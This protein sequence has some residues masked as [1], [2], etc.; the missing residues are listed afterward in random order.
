MA[1]TCP[2]KCQCSPQH[3]ICRYAGLK[4]VPKT[5]PLSVTYIDLS[6]N[7]FL[8]I[9]RNA[10]KNMSLLHTLVLEDCGQKD[11]ITLPSSIEVLTIAD[12]LLADAAFEVMLSTPLPWLKSLR[13]QSNQLNV[14]NILKFIPPS[15]EILQ[16]TG[17]TM[18]ILKSNHLKCCPNLVKFEC[19]YCNLQRIEPNAFDLTR[20][21]S[22]ISLENNALI[23]LPDRIFQHTQKIR[24][25]KL[26]ANLMEKFNASK[27]SLRKLLGID[28]SFNKLKW[29]DLK[30]VKVMDITLANNRI[31]T[32]EANAFEGTSFI[33]ELDLNNNEIT[34]ISQKAF[35]KVRFISTCLLHDNRL[36]HLPR[37]LFNNSVVNQIF[38]HGNRLSNMDGVLE[39]MR[40]PPSFIS[41]FLNKEFQYLNTSNFA[42]MAEHAHIYITC[43]NLRSINSKAKLRAKIECCPSVDVVFYTPFR[44]FFYG[45]YT[46]TWIEESFQFLCRACQAGTFGDAKG[47][48]INCP[49]GSFY[50]DELARKNCKDC[51]PGQYV[52][53][54]KSPGRDP[55]DCQTCPEGTNTKEMAGTRAC[56]CL[57]GFHRTYRFGPCQKCRQVG[58]ECTQDYPQL[59]KGYWMT[60]SGVDS[61]NSACHED[62]KAFIANLNTIDDT[63]DRK[64]MSFNCKLPLPIK[65]PIPGSCNGGVNASC[66]TG[67]SGALCAVCSRGFSKQFN[68][69]VK[70]P[71]IVVALLELIG[72]LALFMLFCLVVSWADK[73]A[74]CDENEVIPSARTRRRTFAD[75]TMSS[76]KILIGF[77]QILLNVFH[78]FSNIDWP[79]NLLRTVSMMKY[80]Q[81]EVIRI[82]SLRCINPD[83]DIDSLKEFWLMLFVTLS[84]PVL[85]SLYFLVKVA[86]M[87]AFYGDTLEFRQKRKLCGRNCMKIVALFLFVTYPLTSA[88]IFGILPISCHKFCTANKKGTCLKEL[89]YLQSDYSISC[90]TMAE[91]KITLVAAYCCLIIPFGLPIVLLLLLWFYS[92][93]NKQNSFE[94]RRFLGAPLI[95]TVGEIDFDEDQLPLSVNSSYVDFAVFEKS[96]KGDSEDMSLAI[97]FAYE[98]YDEKC[99]F[100]EVI[101]M[102]RKLIMTIGVTL[103]LNRTK[104]GLS[105]VIILAMVF[106][107]LHAI[108]K[109]IKDRFENFV[110]LLSLLIVPINLSVGAVLKA[111]IND[112]KEKSAGYSDSVTIGTFLAILN[113]L[114]LVLLVGRI[115]KKAVKKI[116]QK[117]RQRFT[118]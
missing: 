88:R 86:F 79:K 107:L 27:L 18:A 12:N 101:E 58:F 68:R 74:A 85:C 35:N 50:Q 48:C 104:T 52:P 49:S 99:W 17:N 102:I 14:C 45:G 43:K 109:P 31:Q 113:S 62:F 61:D 47:N 69:C 15:I 39:G 54:E 53:P 106:A 46:C 80:I 73:V 59:S 36:S 28:L 25:L 75:I 98:N 4:A 11:P 55:S 76:F 16:L 56:R 83:W 114:L 91:H 40:R 7:P 95:D 70:C 3:F 108:K 57:S 100:W 93:Q 103:F 34:E 33:H 26:K 37:Y 110:Q 96:E 5:I 97:K 22:F 90:P 77:Y 111:K 29:F 44:F 82:P 13:A 115:L 10:F 66:S 81:F 24:F 23:D 8:K 78:A 65:C 84:V 87:S 105:A 67:Y 92:P 60:W 6:Y 118:K 72:Y 63:Y 38:L 30:A 51:P 117:A 89:S 71:H 2:P 1:T 41:L 20:N 64:T 32:I 9:E 116:V 94:D 19:S 42:A 112:D 21:I